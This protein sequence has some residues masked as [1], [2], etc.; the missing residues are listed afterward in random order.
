MF[1]FR[2]P[3]PVIA[4]A[5]LI[6]GLA[7]APG[8]R[9]QGAE[10]SPVRFVTSNDVPVSL[11]SIDASETV[12]QPRGGALVIDLRA[13]VRLRND[14]RGPIRGVSFGVRTGETTLGGKAS[15]AVPGLY[16]SYGETFPVKLALRLL[17]PLPAPAEGIVAVEVDGLL[18]E[19]FRFH[20]PDK[21]DSRRRLTVWAMQADR[22]RAAMRAALASGG[23]EQLQQQVL[24]GLAAQQQRPRLEAR[25]HG[26]T[27]S[28]SARDLAEHRV[29]LA[30]LDVPE[31]PLA[32]L[33]GS[34]LV[35][36][37]TARSPEITVENRSSKPVRYFELGWIVD[38]DRG[39]RYAAGSLPAPTLPFRLAP[40]ESIVTSADRRFSFRPMGEDE[41]RAFA[42]GG[43]R[44]FITQVQFEDGS[45]WIPSR[46]DLRR[47]NLL[48]LLPASPEEQ[49]LTD[50][51][52]RR[53][54]DALIK[55]LNRY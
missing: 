37:R 24:A 46:E 13:T 51:Y 42:V 4:L 9:G 10:R 28:T 22:D 50:L 15:V 34:A 54:L 53:G 17:R 14:G 26:R 19:N 32:A 3:A 29:A 5:L 55:E 7:H 43:L 11:V 21:L 52:R 1:T 45:I 20:G 16:V 23:P 47:A 2:K 40:G 30:F 12:I 25:P 39:R 33:K 36:G 41:N 49:R 48:D 38:D 18:L 44:G 35:A 6:A 8:Q 27:L 31:S